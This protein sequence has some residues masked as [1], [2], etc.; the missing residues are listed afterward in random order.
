M[1]TSDEYIDS[2]K[3]KTTKVEKRAKIINNIILTLLMGFGIT[4]VGIAFYT[5]C[6][7]FPYTEQEPTKTPK[8]LRKIHASNEVAMMKLAFDTGYKACL[9]DVID[10]AS[11]GQGKSDTED[12]NALLEFLHKKTDEVCK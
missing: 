8:G 11:E 3:A 1:K 12:Y 5:L 6:T 7:W 9:W 4:I 2:L 10:I